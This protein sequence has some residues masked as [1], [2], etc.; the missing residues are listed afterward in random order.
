MLP[1]SPRTRRL[2][3]LLLLAV[4]GL[5]TVVLVLSDTPDDRPS[6][7]EPRAAADGTTLT[8]VA[9]IPGARALSVVEDEVRVTDL[10]RLARTVVDAGSGEVG[11]AEVVGGLTRL[12]RSVPGAGARWLVDDEGLVRLDADTGEV[13]EVLALEAP[14]G[15]VAV[16]D[17]AVWL[18]VAGLPV[19]GGAGATT[20]VLQRVDLVT[21]EVLALPVE[22]PVTFRF[23]L[24]EGAAWA[25]AGR[26]LF[27]LDV[28]TLEPTGE[29]ALP[30]P[31]SG[32]VVA[33]GAVWA[34]TSAPAEGGPA[35]LVGF[36]AADLS[37]LEPVLLGPE[38]VGDV[39]VLDGADGPELWVVRPDAG[40]VTHVSL[41]G[42]EPVDVEVEA[43]REIEAD[44]DRLWLT[45]GA[46]GGTLW[47]LDPA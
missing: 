41:P 26:T 7:P 17:D 36:A 5:L 35:T 46:A 16:T 23:A 47:R 38:A 13:V 2:A 43:P 28:A 12:E 1:R 25:T 22:D 3:A 19:E 45:S 32:L 29:V 6:L 21:G 31:A 14:G 39:A 34:V 10:D 18:T 30:E 37:P 27:R 42:G 8:A 44:G 20:S 33:D 40:R 9:R 15:V 4:A 24:G 11:E